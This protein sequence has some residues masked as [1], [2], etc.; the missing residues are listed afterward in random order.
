MPALAVRSSVYNMLL[1]QLHPTPEQLKK[2]AGR[3][4][5]SIDSPIGATIVAL[6]KHKLETPENKKLLKVSYSLFM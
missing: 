5:G 2:T 6:R 1:N 4:L 3:G